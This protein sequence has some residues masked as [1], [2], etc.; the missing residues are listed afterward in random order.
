[1]LPSNDK[2]SF[3]CVLSSLNLLHYDKWKDTDADLHQDT[4]R[5]Q[6]AQPRQRE[7][8]DP[9]QPLWGDRALRLRGRL[10]LSVAG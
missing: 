7:A 6:N 4:H 1:M 3:V 10:G 2:W 8:Q 9:G 5:L